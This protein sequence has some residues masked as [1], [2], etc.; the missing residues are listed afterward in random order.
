MEEYPVLF[1]KESNK[2]MQ[3]IMFFKKIRFPLDIDPLT[4]V[5]LKNH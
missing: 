3:H 4:I 2:I 1:Q 5:R